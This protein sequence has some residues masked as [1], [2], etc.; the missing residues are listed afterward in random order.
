MVGMIRLKDRFRLERKNVSSRDFTK[1]H[2]KSVKLLVL[3]SNEG[4]EKTVEQMQT[5]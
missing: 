4:P 2:K 3:H 5:Q 1:E